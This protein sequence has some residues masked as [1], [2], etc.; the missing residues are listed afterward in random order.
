M[1]F[2]R[3]NFRECAQ[4]VK[5]ATYTKMARPTLEYAL[6][7][8][9]PHKQND[10]QL[11]ERV[12]RRAARYVTNNY[13]DRLPDTVTSQLEN[14][15]WTSTEHRRRQICLGMFYKINDGLVDINPASFSTTPTLG[16]QKHNDCLRNIPN[17][18]CSRCPPLREHQ[19]R[20][21]SFN[22][23]STFIVLITP[24]ALT[25]TIL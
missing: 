22:V 17:T 15:K 9:A 24:K 25:V 7:V 18:T 20:V 10:I 5:S 21:F 1:G 19:N 2:L 13:T 8:W 6:A 11:L 12:Q 23:T 14:L 16:P 3:R 4:K